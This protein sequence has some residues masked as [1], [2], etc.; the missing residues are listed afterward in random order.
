[1]SYQPTTV[2]REI[3]S[4]ALQNYISYKVKTRGWKSN[5]SIETTTSTL[6]I[7]VREM[8][9]S[10]GRPALTDDLTDEVV[11]SLIHARW[12]DNGR[13]KTH[14]V[15][16]ARIKSF[17]GWLAASQYHVGTVSVF[18][19]TTPEA[20]QT[21]V[22]FLTREEAELTFATVHPYAP[23]D[24]HLVW[25]AFLLW[26]RPAEMARLRVGDINLKPRHGADHG[27]Y[28]YTETKG[29]KGRITELLT[30]SQREALEAWLEEY[31]TI[32]GVKKLSHDWYLFPQAVGVGIPD[33]ITRKRPRRLV[34]EYPMK[35]VHRV[36]SNAFKDAGVYR[37]W[38][39]GH[40]ARRGGATD[41]FDALEDAGIP[42]PLKHIQRRLGH[43][44]RETSSIYI[45]K[46][47]GKLKTHKAFQLV[48]DIRSGKTS[49]PQ[50][51]PVKQDSEQLSDDTPGE[52]AKI[53]H[54]PF[55][56]KR[57]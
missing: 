13:S 24:A 35:E 53:I 18:L 4:T 48:D 16:Y 37:R 49:S 7:F 11:I 20:P 42:D 41:G 26:R 43:T 51:E 21:E 12:P 3:L 36:Y 1:M 27:T 34:P 29:H 45:R 30:S 5:A 44:K 56:R 8:D 55:G 23:R 50:A 39:A 54:L 40:S 52:M 17:V 6:N 47:E 22:E 10:L 19:G 46:D 25:I 32:M 9:K 57:A 15:N 28:T 33:E 14:Y 38:K 2:T 31:R